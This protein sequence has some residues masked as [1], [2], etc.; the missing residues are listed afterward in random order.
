MIGVSSYA[1]KAIAAVAR[2][3]AAVTRA[4]ALLVQHDNVRPAG[5]DADAI[6]NWNRLRTDL[7]MRVGASEEALAFAEGAAE[8]ALADAAERDADAAHRQEQKQAAADTKLV[9]EADALALKLAAKLAEIKASGERTAAVNARR[10]S[11]PFIL[12]A[13]TQVRQRPARVEPAIVEE[14]QVWRSP[15]GEAPTFFSTTDTG[16]LVPTGSNAGAYRLVTENVTVRPEQS[17]PAHM[18]ARLT[19]TVSLVT[20]QGDRLWPR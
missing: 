4:R 5:D 12:D 13:E 17:I 8:K 18:P 3:Q 11:R 16:D 7:V 19:E 20:L 14:R 15:N 6:F 2:N 1:D 10:G 9:R